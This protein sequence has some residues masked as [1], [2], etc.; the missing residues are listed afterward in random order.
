MCVVLYVLYFGFFLM[1][2]QKPYK[3]RD[4]K[5]AQK[6]QTES[7]NKR[8]ATSAPRINNLRPSSTIYEVDTK[9]L[10]IGSKV[11]FRWTLKNK[12]WNALW[13]NQHQ[14]ILVYGKCLRPKW[15]RTQYLFKIPSLAD[16]TKK[17]NNINLN[18]FHTVQSEVWPMSILIPAH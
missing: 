17:K 4:H 13:Q 11:S 2:Y 16:Y 3:Q 5:S 18:L 6:I 12:R 7:K 8:F 15:S 9:Y 1:S 14:S 10:S